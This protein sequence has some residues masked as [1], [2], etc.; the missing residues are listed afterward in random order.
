MIQT[1][2]T[3]E[4]QIAKAK[5]LLSQDSRNAIDA[6]N[7][8]GAIEV[9]GK[10]Y[11]AIQLET[12]ETETELLLCGLVNTIDFPKELEARMKIPKV[13]VSML[14][15]EM[16]RLIFKK[17]QE[18]LE[19]RLDNS[20]GDNKNV[21]DKNKVLV[22]DLR[23]TSLPKDIQES[24][25]YS[26]WKEKLYNI[27]R[28]YKINVEQM[29]I[30]EDITVKVILNTIAGNQYED[31]IRSKIDLGNDKIKEMVGE[32]NENIFK[33]IKRAEKEGVKVIKNEES[34]IKNEKTDKVPLPPYAKIIK[35][36]EKPIQA[37]NEIEN[38]ISNTL[39]N[40]KETDMYKEH[41]IE[42]IN[43]D[44]LP[45]IKE[46]TTS[47][48]KK[49]EEI[50]KE[51]KIF[52]ST[53]AGEEIKLKQAN[54]TNENITIPE[55]PKESNIIANKLFGN[56]ASSVSVS[57][58]SLPKMSGEPQSKPHDPYHEEI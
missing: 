24:I 16:D 44:Q 31:A 29:G 33:D 42:I 30:L 4:I 49:I 56:T 50:V 9:M 28:K 2:D 38:I 53:L 47:P 48:V 11:S 13:E 54:P 6:V 36:E 21:L 32:I 17:M 7:W 52:S 46:E 37:Q 26:N 12:L 3:L 34:G 55:K 58:Y 5:A 10:K 39:K 51:N 8:R 19:K 25:A 23:F 35:N 41:G 27:A 14:L 15:N 18:E 43:N 40:T 22:F 20:N 57:D 45:I 1:T